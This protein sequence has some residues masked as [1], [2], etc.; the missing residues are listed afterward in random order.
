MNNCP[1]NTC[2]S[3]Y[4]AE[5]VIYNIDNDVPSKLSNLNIPNKSNLSFILEKIDT[6]LGNNFSIVLNKEDS[7]SVAITLNGPTIKADAK[8]SQSLGNALEIKNDG[9]FVKSSEGKVKVS[10]TDNSPNYLTYKVIG[11]TDSVVSI[12]VTEVNGVLNI[13]PNLNIQ[14]LLSAISNNPTL[15]AYFKN[16]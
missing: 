15:L 14:A 9:L 2:I 13:K 4:N 3:N 6:L 1:T 10:S 11:G 7:N 8:L 16:M 5:C 12:S